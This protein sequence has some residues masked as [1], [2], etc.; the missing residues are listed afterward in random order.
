M[1]RT[2]SI[3]H[4]GLYFYLHNLLTNELAKQHKHIQSTPTPDQLTYFDQT[5]TV[6]VMVV[7]ADD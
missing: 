1:G 4:I 7:A 3:F 6:V 5:L 2:A